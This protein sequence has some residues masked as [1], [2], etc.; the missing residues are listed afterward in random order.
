MSF[1]KAKQIHAAM[2]QAIAS[3]DH[4]AAMKHSGQML[5][6]MMGVASSQPAQSAAASEPG[7]DD[8]QGDPTVPPITAPQPQPAQPMSTGR[9]GHGVGNFIH[10][11]I[12]HPGAFTKQAKSAG[13]SVHQF[14]EQKK[15]ASGTT[16]NRA[17][18]ALTLKKINHGRKS[19]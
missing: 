1:A 8:D 15:H 13:E 12:K 6:A 9:K 7:A 2:G 18:L 4:Q 16:G 5:K 11:D 10:S 14:A 19:A 17:R 3:G